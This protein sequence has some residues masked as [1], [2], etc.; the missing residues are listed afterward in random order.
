M[1]VRMSCLAHAHHNPNPNPN[2]TPSS[3]S[4]RI[5]MLSTT[6]NP[7]SHIRSNI[8]LQKVFE[9]KS[10]GI[11]CY[12]DDKGEITCEGY[13]EGPRLHRHQHLGSFSWNQRDGEAIVHLLKT[14]LLLVMDGGGN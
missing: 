10:S 4:K 8:K 14:S 2:P 12:R 13:D 3:T 5:F 9:D 1:A 7:S 11:V 6:Q